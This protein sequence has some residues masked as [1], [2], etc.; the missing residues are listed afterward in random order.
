MRSRNVA[1]NRRVTAASASWNI[2][3]FECRVIFAPILTDF[4]HSV[5]HDQCFTSRGRASRRKKFVR[6]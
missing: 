2:M 6:L 3:Y 4:S 1:D 5:V